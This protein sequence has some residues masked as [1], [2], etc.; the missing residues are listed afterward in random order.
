MRIIFFFYTFELIGT[1]EFINYFIL[2]IVWQWG[3][4][5]VIQLALPTSYYGDIQD[6]NF[7]TPNFLIN[8]NNNKIIW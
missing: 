6:S 3:Q 8:N 5:L 1:H 4:E 7:P 2:L